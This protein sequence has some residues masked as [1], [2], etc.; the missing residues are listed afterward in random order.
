MYEKNIKIFTK[1]IIDENCFH[2]RKEA[3][4]LIMVQHKWHKTDVS[5]TA[6]IWSTSLKSERGL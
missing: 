6:Q 1:I 5:V 4:N 3:G 2:G